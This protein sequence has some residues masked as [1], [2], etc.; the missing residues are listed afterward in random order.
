VDLILV[1]KHVAVSGLSHRILTTVKISKCTNYAAEN[2]VFTFTY[3]IFL[4]KA[5]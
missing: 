3:M 1:E 5:T 4:S 2:Q